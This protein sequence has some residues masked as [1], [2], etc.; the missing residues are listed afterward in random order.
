[1]KPATVFVT[2]AGNFVLLTVTRFRE[3]LY[4]FNCGVNI[5][6]LLR[7]R[8]ALYKFCLYVLFHEFLLFPLEYR[9]TLKRFFFYLSFL[10]LETAGRTPWKGDQPHSKVAANRTQTQN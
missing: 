10:I 5:S 6:H 7:W 9:A 4:I 3:G 1:M 2:V 8:L